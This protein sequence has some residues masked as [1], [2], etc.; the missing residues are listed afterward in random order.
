VNPTSESVEGVFRASSASVTASLIRYCGDFDLA[1]DAVQEAFVVAVDHWQREGIPPN[2]GGWIATTAKR[3][4]ID[5]LRREKRRADKYELL[6]RVESMPVDPVNSEDELLRLVFTCCHPALSFDVRVALTLRTVCGLNTSQIA[7]AFVV[8][9]PTMAQRLVRGRRKIR[10]AGI[11]YEVP[12]TEDLEGRL[13]SVLSV[14][15]LVFNAGYDAVDNPDHDTSHLSDEAIRLARRLVLLM[16]DQ[17]EIMGLLALMLLHDA[18]SSGRLDVDGEIV[19]LE[20]QNRDVWDHQQIGEAFE[21]VAQAPKF[22]SVGQYWLQAAIVAEHLAPTVSGGTDWLRI[23]DLYDLLLE[24]TDHSEIVQLNRAVALAEARGPAAGLDVLAK[25]EGR[26]VDFP[27]FHA[28]RAEL[29]KRSGDFRGAAA[30]YRRAID[31]TTDDARRRS[32]LTALE[33][34]KED[35]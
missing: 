26:L 33:N 4:L 5:R 11:P 25:I 29:L 10:V 6:A 1:E 34:V 18:R 3:R 27:P 21:L 2:P 9:E 35:A 20:Q 7:A 19:L 24:Q 15:Y 31:L 12:A 22:G 16:P 17:P 14:L 13:R 23:V 32:L 28:A 8:P 30:A